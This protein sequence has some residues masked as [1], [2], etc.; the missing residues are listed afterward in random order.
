MKAA[1]CF[2][3]SYDH[4]LN[5][6]EIWKEWIRPNQDIINV[7]FHYKDYD[8]ISSNWIKE[9]AIPK[10]Y[11]VETSYYYV[12]PAYMS[13]LSWAEKED[14]ENQWFCMLTESCV[15]II[16][17]SR[18]RRL[19]FQNYNKS[20]MRWKPAWWNVKFQKRANLRLLPAEYHIGND[21]WFILCKTDVQTCEWFSIETKKIYNTVCAGGL[22]NESIFAI[23]LKYF[24]RLPFV[25]NEVTHL[26]D[27][28]RRTSSTSP[29]LFKDNSKE[30]IEFIE[31]G[32]AENKCA[33][34]LRKV[35]TDFPD[36]V[37]M[38]YI[39]KPDEDFESIVFGTSTEFIKQFLFFLFMMVA[40]KLVMDAVE[41]NVPKL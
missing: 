7:Y 15:P 11:T 37:L 34:F 31:N 4:N 1:L 10:D 12:V 29:W 5:K 17:P 18:F 30:N 39:N 24:Q 21:P 16:S 14:V 19:F 41:F 3:I 20:I 8:K 2:I 36:D 6:E 22:A 38:E 28:N 13:L 9:R 35:A 25:K 27:W 33:I 40:F 32:L 26:T 23:A